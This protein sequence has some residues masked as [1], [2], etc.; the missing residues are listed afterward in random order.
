LPLR[1]MSPSRLQIQKRI[2]TVSKPL[3]ASAPYQ[4]PVGTPAR[5]LCD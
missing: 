4:N 2:K 1:L 3:R 5:S